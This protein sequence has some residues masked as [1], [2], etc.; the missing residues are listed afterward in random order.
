M[1]LML[2]AWT[3]GLILSLLGLGVFVAGVT[4]AIWARRAGAAL[5]IVVLLGIAFVCLSAT[6]LP[7]GVAVVLTLVALSVVGISSG[8][9][10][11]STLPISVYPQATR[12]TGVGF[13]TA[14]G[15]IGG[16]VGPTLGGLFLALGMPAGTI[17]PLLAVPIGLAW[18]CLVVVARR[19][20]QVELGSVAEPNTALRSEA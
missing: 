10:G 19:G 2:G 15:R 1:T 18:V 3:V 5:P 4:L 11:Q 17:I 6:S 8:S 12:T 20:R 16:I 14:A 9:V 7:V 13:T